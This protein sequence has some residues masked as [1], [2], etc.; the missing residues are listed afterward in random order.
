[1]RILN[2]TL[3]ILQILLL[4]LTELHSSNESLLVDVV[5]LYTVYHATYT[6]VTRHL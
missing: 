4:N 2:Y 3:Q 6:L 5:L 1:M